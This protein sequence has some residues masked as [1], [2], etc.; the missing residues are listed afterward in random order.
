MRANF[1]GPA[2]AFMMM[3]AFATLPATLSAQAANEMPPEGEGPAARPPAA[4][5]AI[6]QLKSPYCPGM[7]LEVCPSGGGMALR[8]SLQAMALQGSSADELVDWV[9]GNHGDHWLAMPRRSGMSLI[10]AWLVPP[11]GVL[12]GL[13]LAFVALRRMR[14]TAPRPATHEGPLSDADEARLRDALRELDAEEEATFF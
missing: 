13:G 7:M 12:A 3:V 10:L 6:D 4:Q 9:L 5:E 14:S 8:D 2:R 1:A 11:F